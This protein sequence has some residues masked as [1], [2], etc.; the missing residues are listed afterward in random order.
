M[1]FYVEKPCKLGPG[2]YAA[3]GDVIEDGV[4]SDEK[5]GILEM[6]R[7]ISRIQE[8]PIAQDVEESAPDPEPDQPKRKTRKKSD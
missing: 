6:S 2:M 8:L 7:C 4:L 5:I 3:Q 1:S